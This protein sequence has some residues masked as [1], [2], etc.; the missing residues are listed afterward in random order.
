MGAK[1]EV[2]IRFFVHRFVFF[3]SSNCSLPVFRHLWLSTDLRTALPGFPLNMFCFCFRESVV[4]F[5]GLLVSILKAGSVPTAVSPNST[6][7]EGDFVDSPVSGRGSGLR[8]A[9][10]LM[11]FCT[12]EKSARFYAD[13][14]GD[15]S[16]EKVTGSRTSKT[17]PQFSPSLET[18]M[19]PLWS[20]TSRFTSV[21]PIPRPALVR[22]GEGG[23]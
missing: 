21:S 20:S 13:P 2:K 4:G 1:R 16:S 18:A 11:A 15:F 6:A 14:D 23:S 9:N 5:T 7:L 22:S 19:E 8:N 3:V 17:L 12:E 10:C